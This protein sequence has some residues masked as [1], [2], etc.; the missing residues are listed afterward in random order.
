MSS[1][2]AQSLIAHVT[3]QAT[4]KSETFAFDSSPVRLGRNPLNEM[5][6]TD[7]TVSQWHGL[8]RFDEHQLSYVDLG[9]TN[10]TALNGQR[11]KRNESITLKAGDL[12]QISQINIKVS[13]ARLPKVNLSSKECTFLQESEERDRTIMLDVDAASVLAAITLKA[14]PEDV[15]RVTLQCSV[16]YKNYQRALNDAVD[17]LGICLEQLPK[18]S[19]GPVALALRDRIPDLAETTR[20]R[21]FANKLGLRPEQLGHVD[22]E[23]W[24]GRLLHGLEGASVLKGKVDVHE[25]M[26]RLGAI[27]ETF[28][29]SYLD[30]HSGYQQFLAGMGLRLNTDDGG[31]LG[32]SKTAREALAYLL[33]GDGKGRIRELNRAFA[34]LALHQVALLNGVVEGVRGMLGDISPEA[35][36][37]LPGG[38]ESV[39]VRTASGGGIFGSRVKQW[40]RDFAEKYSDLTVEERFTK[41]MFGRAFSRAYLTI[42]G[43]TDDSTRGV[44]A[45]PKIPEGLQTLPIGASN[46]RVG[47]G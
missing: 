25:A 29:Q 23:D 38:E 46:R 43:N 30:L 24:L 11:V 47:S 34:D 21:T 17:H 5:T 4:K 16:A 1:E 6:V 31:R 28:A 39:A 41:H 27:L 15:D 3:N 18:A 40:W 37:G 33:D 36:A 14:K 35:I 10:G 26:P 42:M 8:F 44:G 45:G 32:Q 13:R 9:S 2:L 22:I 20:F 7:S 12:L 19:R